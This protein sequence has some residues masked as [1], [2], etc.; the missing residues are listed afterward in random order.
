M[1]ATTKIC[2]KGHLLSTVFLLNN[3]PVSPF[4]NFHSFSAQGDVFQVS[5][6]LHL[7]NKA[8]DH[9]FNIG[10]PMNKG[11]SLP[12]SR[13]HHL[14]DKLA[15]IRCSKKKT[16]SLVYFAPWCND[17][18]KGC[19]PNVILEAWGRVK[20]L[21]FPFFSPCLYK[22]QTRNLFYFS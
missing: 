11:I 19:D 4:V 13:V 7:A 22:L 17:L 3:Y 1:S 6:F 5:L 10:F 12:H 2:R 8:V 21:Q 15:T 9:A 18:V 16:R 20:G 14:G